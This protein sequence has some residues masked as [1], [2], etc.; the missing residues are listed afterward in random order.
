MTSVTTV[1][2]LN[3]F[4]MVRPP[5]KRRKPRRWTTFKSETVLGPLDHGLGGGTWANGFVVHMDVV[6]FNDEVS[7]QMTIKQSFRLSF[8]MEIAG[9]QRRTRNA[10]MVLDAGSASILAH[11]SISARVRR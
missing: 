5:S 4:N 2:S 9:L 10:E 6:T 3:F 1:R 8:H 11:G 7:A